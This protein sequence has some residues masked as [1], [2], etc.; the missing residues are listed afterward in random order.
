ACL[1]EQALAERLSGTKR[2][3]AP[4]Q[5]GVDLL[6]ARDGDGAEY[7][8]RA[9]VDGV[10]DGGGVVADVDSRR[11]LDADTR[12]AALAEPRQGTGAA[13]WVAL[14]VEDVARGQR[15]LGAELCVL[16]GGE[17]DAGHLELHV[18]HDDRRAF[19]DGE[20]DVGDIAA[21][22]HRHRTVHLG[23]IVAAAAVKG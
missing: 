9:G 17:L 12:P 1:V 20:G 23:P 22:T 15:D 5:L 11:L 4:H 18:L 3:L 10:A 6:D 13:R 16:L 2:D 14:L 7:T 19:V 8:W 21:G